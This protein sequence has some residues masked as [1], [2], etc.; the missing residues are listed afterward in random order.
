MAHEVLG[1]LVAGERPP[2]RRR[3]AQRSPELIADAYS[4][5]PEDQPAAPAGALARFAGA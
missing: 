2:L 5:T 1:D 4:F 3:I